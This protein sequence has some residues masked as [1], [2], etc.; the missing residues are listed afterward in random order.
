MQVMFR[1]MTGYRP[2]IPDEMPAGY[3]QLMVACWDEEPANR[4]PFTD[5][6]TWLRRLKSDDPGMAGSS[7]RNSL[8]MHNDWETD[9]QFD[10]RSRSQPSTGLPPPPVYSSA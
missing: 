9:T 10:G 8:D 2:P 1:V 4:P 7:G 5:I 6:L 3:R